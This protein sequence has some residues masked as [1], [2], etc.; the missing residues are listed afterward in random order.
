ML[1]HQRVSHPLPS[2]EMAWRFLGLTIDGN[3]ATWQL[4]TL[5]HQH[6]SRISRTTSPVNYA[7]DTQMHEKKREGHAVENG[8]VMGMSCYI[9]YIS[10]INWTFDDF[11]HPVIDDPLIESSNHW[12]IFPPARRIFGHA[13]VL[14]FGSIDFLEV[15]GF[16][17]EGWRGNR[18]DISGKSVGNQW[19]IS[20]KSV[21]NHWEIIII[22]IWY[23][24]RINMIYSYP[25]AN[26][27]T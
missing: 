9:C 27:L 16:F 12:M 21:G 25:L 10:I 5:F 22:W 19:D 15:H 7:A 20:W 13:I 4:K 3:I 17:K 24:G 18:W 11:K 8:K 23:G 14:L 26:I 2:V 6:K 1:V